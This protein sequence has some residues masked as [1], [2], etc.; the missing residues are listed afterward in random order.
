METRGLSYDWSTPFRTWPSKKLFAHWRGH[1]DGHRTSFRYIWP[2][3][4]ASNNYSRHP[5]DWEKTSLKPY[6]DILEAHNLALMDEERRAK[7]DAAVSMGECSFMSDLM[8]NGFRSPADMSW[9]KEFSKNCTLRRDCISTT[10]AGNWYFP[11]PWFDY[12]L[13]THVRSSLWGV[14][15]ASPPW[16]TCFSYFSSLFL[17]LCLFRRLPKCCQQSQLLV[18]SF[19]FVTSLLGA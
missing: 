19:Y 7:R 14:R 12:D 15:I 3:F 16:S 2:S 5:L 10:C 6:V 8:D 13:C 9:W 18:A 17:S 11:K 4:I 1:G